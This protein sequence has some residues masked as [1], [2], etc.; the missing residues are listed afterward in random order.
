MN[1]ASDKVESGVMWWQNILKT[2]MC[3]YLEGRTNA[4]WSHSSR[5]SDEKKLGSL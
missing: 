4:C 5:V 2:L 3:N 1:A